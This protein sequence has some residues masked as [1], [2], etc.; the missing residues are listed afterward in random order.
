MR[1]RLLIL[2]SFS[3]LTLGA[4][5]TDKSETDTVNDFSKEAITNLKVQT[6]AYTD[7]ELQAGE[8][9]LNEYIQ[10]EGEITKTD[11]G[12]E[13][14]KGDRFVLQSGDSQYQVFNEQETPLALGDRVTVYGEYY[15][16]I[17]GMLIER[18]E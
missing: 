15:G 18:N 11:G 3:L 7:E 17:K 4:C 8:V 5:G 2:L 16:I 10:I 1:K 9:P 13:I 12:K 14:V 6:K